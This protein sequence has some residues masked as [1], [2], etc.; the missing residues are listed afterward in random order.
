MGFLEEKKEW[1]MASDYYHFDE[2]WWRLSTI[3]IEVRHECDTD[4]ESLI[5]KEEFR[6]I[7]N[8]SNQNSVEHITKALQHFWKEHARWILA[9]TDV[10]IVGPWGHVM[11]RKGNYQEQDTVSEKNYHA[12]LKYKQTQ[13]STQKAYV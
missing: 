2:V 11:K 3:L 10:L 4:S 6:R 12:I 1:S 8:V 13:N 9:T 5:L 7:L